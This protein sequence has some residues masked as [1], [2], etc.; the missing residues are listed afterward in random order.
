MGQ[1]E[2]KV[3]RGVMTLVDDQQRLALERRADNPWVD[4]SIPSTRTNLYVKPIGT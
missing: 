4:G 3:D 1:E 2:L